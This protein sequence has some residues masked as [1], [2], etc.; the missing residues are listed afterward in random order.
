MPKR[1]SVL[2]KPFG[3]TTS[4]SP[5][6]PCPTTTCRAATPPWSSKRRAPLTSSE[7]SPMP[8]L[9][10]VEDQR[11][12]ER[13]QDLRAPHDEA[14]GLAGPPGPRGDPPRASAPERSRSTAASPSTIAVSASS[15]LR[16]PG[17]P[18]P[19]FSFCQFPPQRRRPAPV[20]R[21][22]TPRRRRARARTR[23]RSRAACPSAH[24]APGSRGSRSG[25]RW[26][27]PRRRSSRRPRA[28]PSRSRT[29]RGA[30]RTRRPARSR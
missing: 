6:P 18:W 17:T 22:G 30:P 15:K 27:R 14:T 1:P 28:R 2:K 9:E 19:P 16:K 26:S 8:G 23:S 29:S 3:P 12:A 13:S 11:P 20:R 10:T 7:R 21:S 5:S 24:P 4:S 25:R